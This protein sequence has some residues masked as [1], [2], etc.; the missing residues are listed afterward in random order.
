MLKTH[1]PDDKVQASAFYGTSGALA[2]VDALKRAGPELTREGF[3]SA[4]N[5]TSGLDGGPLACTLSFKADAHEG[6]T[7][8]SIWGLRDDKITVLGDHW[9]Q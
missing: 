6:C 9:E 2:V 1:Y 5:E 3:V 8:G 4:M 7:T